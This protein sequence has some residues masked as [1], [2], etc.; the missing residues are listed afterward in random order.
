MIISIS[1]P[2]LL[3]ITDSRTT[4][5]FFGGIQSWYSTE[6]SRRAGCGPT[7]A[8]NI[9]AYLALSRPELL[10]LYNHRSMERSDFSQSME[11]VYQFVHSFIIA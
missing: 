9:L 5:R 7:C 11:E 8:T 4:Q 10:S 3:T 2:D 1:R 6:W